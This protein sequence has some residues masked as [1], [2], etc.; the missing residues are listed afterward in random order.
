ML[1][2]EDDI[3]D[4]TDSA[5]KQI[6][7]ENNLREIVDRWTFKEFTFSVWGKRDTPCMLN[8]LSVQEITETLEE[9]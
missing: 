6:K 5:D 7:I 4:I 1:A 2:H 8:G 3:V 9:D